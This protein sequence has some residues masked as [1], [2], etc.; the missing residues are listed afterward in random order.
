M[1]HKSGRNFWSGYNNH[2]IRQ[3]RRS[4]QLRQRLRVRSGL[5]RLD[6]KPEPRPS[7]RR[8]NQHG[9]G[10]GKL[11]A[12][13]RSARSLR[14]N[15]TKRRRPRRRDGRTAFFH[16]AQ[17]RLHRKINPVMVKIDSAFWKTELFPVI[18]EIERLS[19][20]SKFNTRLADMF[21]KQVML[22][23]FSVRTLIERSKLSQELLL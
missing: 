21:E 3:R 16:R 18:E 8:T 15:E 10:L 22:A 14:R 17:E 12:R 6:T 13:A 11:L 5:E 23:L 7:R 9:H 19:K 4:D 2:A 1:L 20:F